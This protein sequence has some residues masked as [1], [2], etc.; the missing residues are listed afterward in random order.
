MQKMRTFA[1]GAAL[2]VSAVSTSL[3]AD[4]KTDYDH[5]ADFS[6]I[7]TYSWG[8][9]TTADPFY[10]DRIKQQVDKVLQ[11]KGWQM[12]PSGGDATVFAKGNVKTEKELETYYDGFG[13]GWG[14]G[15]GWGG[16]GGPWGWGGPGETT[17][18]VSTQ[19]VGYLVIDVFHGQ[20]K[21][22]MWRGSSEDNIAKNSEKNTDK[23]DK[24]IDKM[25]KNFPPKGR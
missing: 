20:S 12:V 6:K 7:H 3:A 13:G 21:H 10:V 17:T 18:S 1:L 15:W 11:A 8:Q 4:V 23:L 16:W 25:F 22:L 14:G 19:K 2:L 9:V 24:D 5:S